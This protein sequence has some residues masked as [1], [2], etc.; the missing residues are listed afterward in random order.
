MAALEKGMAGGFLQ[1]NAAQ[2]LKKLVLSKEIRY[3]NHQEEVLAF[4]G[5]EQSADYAPQSVAI[6]GIVKEMDGEIDKSNMEAQ[7]K[8]IESNLE[9]LNGKSLTELTHAMIKLKLSPG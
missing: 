7:L 4:L 8:A 3:E 9:G 1:T 5:N 6:T 2:L